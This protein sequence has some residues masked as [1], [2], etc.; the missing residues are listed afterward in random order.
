MRLNGWTSPQVVRRYGASA[1]GARARRSY[2][3]VMEDAS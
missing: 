1:S 3:R 2:D